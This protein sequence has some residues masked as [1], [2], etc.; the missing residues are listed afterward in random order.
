MDYNAQNIKVLKGLEPVRQRPGMYIGSTGKAGLHHL[1]YEIVDN[2]VDEA[3][4][5]YCDKIYVT[6]FKDGSVEIKDNGRGIPVD[7]HP[8]TGKSALEVVMTTLHAGGKFSKDSYKVS[9]GL[10]G[11][12]ASVVNALSEWLEVEVHR[13]GKI[14][15]QKY[16][17]GTPLTEVRIIGETDYRGTIVRFKPDTEIFSTVEFDSDT[18]LIRLRELAF[19]NPNITVVFKD[20]RENIEKTF[21]FTG[22]LKEFVVHLSKGTRSLHEP[23]LVSGE[24]NSIKVD[25]CFQYT[26][27]DFEKIY[28]FV[29]NIRTVDGGT[30]VTGFKTAF[31][32]VVNELGKKTGQL[33]K[34]TLRGEDIREGIVAIVS[35]L[36]SKTPEFEGQTKSKLGNEEVQEAV[37]KVVREKLLE[38]FE[39]NENTL[40]IIIQKALEAKKA[41]EAAK[42]AREMIKRKSVFGSSSL[43]GKLA[44]CITKK[45]EESELFIVEGDSA[46]GSAKQARDRNFQAILPLRG[47]ILNVEKSS[48]L[49]L[50]KNEQIRDIITALGTGIGDDFDISKL[51]YGKIIIMTDADVD[52]AHIRTL[53]LTL[54]YRYMKELIDEGRIYIAQPPL[55]KVNVNKK[56][57]Y[58]YS[59]EELEEFKENLKD[60]KFEIQRYKGLGEM[61]PQQL[62]ET[63][64]DPEKRK[65]LKVE[66]E[67][68]EEADEL[69]EMLMGSDTESR[70]EFIFRH[71]LQVKEIDI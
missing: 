63:T 15:Y 8:E 34:D 64:M 60:K 21:H 69:F 29:N 53:L 57:Y 56:I 27:S 70:K 31:T 32:R 67:D 62:W 30:H 7:I 47:K 1:V 16:Q 20:E 10:H 17:R 44:D 61:N 66:I 52:G 4:Q 22:G 35:V 58:F 40:K 5:G 55:Y 25:V 18:I 19:L 36:M 43:P 51:R 6:I 49:K 50:L 41:R 13:D 9:G 24:Y 12:G 48:W 65:L 37:A 3:L 28:S 33:K 46:G 54:F 42:H 26:A 38:Y 45:M 59:D 23:I 11:V 2:S 14:Y 71:A 68:A 39:S